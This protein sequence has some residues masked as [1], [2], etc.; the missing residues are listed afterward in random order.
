MMSDLSTR[1][2]IE[3]FTVFERPK[4]SAA[5][6]LAVYTVPEV[7]QLHDKPSSFSVR[8]HTLFQSVL[9]SRRKSFYL[10]FF[11]SIAKISGKFKHHRIFYYT[12]N[13][14]Q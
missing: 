4:N 11:L 14:L 7:F 12:D 8:T 13:L 9:Y 1:N 3:K 10:A 2:A 6:L 5:K